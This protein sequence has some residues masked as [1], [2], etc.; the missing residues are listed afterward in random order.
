M[1]HADV[2]QTPLQH[3]KAIILQEKKKLPANAGD[4]DSSPGPEDSTG[5]GATKHVCPNY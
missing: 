2:W 4:T 1:I 5:P 3:C